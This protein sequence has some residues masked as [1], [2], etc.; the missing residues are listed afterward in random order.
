MTENPVALEELLAARK[1]LI[2]QIVGGMPD[3]H[4]RFLISFERGAPDWTL[5]DLANA[6]ELPAVRWRQQ[7]LDGLDKTKRA[8]LVASLESLLLG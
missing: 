7:N 5:L 2:E 8:E 3:A 1:S 6:A 4:R